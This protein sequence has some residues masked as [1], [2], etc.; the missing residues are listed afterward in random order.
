MY[1]QQILINFLQTHPVE[2]IVNCIILFI[3]YPIDIILLSIL[4]TKTYD[5]LNK[6]KRDPIPFVKEAALLI[7]VLL[8]LE[9]LMDYREWMNAQFYPELEQF[10]RNEIIN[11]TVETLSGN[12]YEVESGDFQARL[13]KVPWVVSTIYDSFNK[14]IAPCFFTFLGITLFMFFIDKR[15][16]FFSFLFMVI[17]FSVFAYLYYSCFQKSQQ[18]DQEENKMMEQID[19]KIRNLLNIFTS[20]EEENELSLL[21]TAQEAYR[22]LSTDEFRHRTKVDFLIGL[23]DFT[24]LAAMFA[25]I[26]W[27]RK[28]LSQKQIVLIITVLLFFIRYLRTF[29]SESLLS[30]YFLATIYDNN[31][32]FD[33]LK[34]KQFQKTGQQRDFIRSGTIQIENLS[35]EKDNTPILTNFSATIPPHTLTLLMGPSGSGKSSIVKLI[36]GFYEPSAGSILIDGV[37]IHKANLAYLRSHITYI[38]QHPTLFQGSIIENIIYGTQMTQEEALRRIQQLPILYL[39]PQDLQAPVGKLGDRLSGGQRQIVIF[40]RAYLRKNPILLIDEP[41]AAVDPDHRELIYDMIQKLSRHSTTLVITHD[42][43]FY[44]YAD[45]IIQTHQE[46]NST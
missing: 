3:Y 31:K 16:G 15:F 12:Y 25:L 19:D 11:R 29:S 23:L 36:Q 5:Q 21:E 27:F 18:R 45:K 4:F 37:P 24:Y 35:Y 7:G 22:K 41:T 33:S 1:I 34:T 8:S 9:F 43:G 44:P 6:V 17:Y 38:P 30:S 42:T 2:A 46:S 10:T 40:L 28:S 26:V 39:L 20:G 14:Y 13:T 32:Y